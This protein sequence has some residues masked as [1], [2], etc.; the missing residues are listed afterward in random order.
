M[1]GKGCE[2]HGFL[3]E[4]FK[5]V[6]QFHMLMRQKLP[7]RG[8]RGNCRSDPEKRRGDGIQGTSGE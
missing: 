3:K 7:W 4:L 1:A 5:S 2:V 8:R 6:K